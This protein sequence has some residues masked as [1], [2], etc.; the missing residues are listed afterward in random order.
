MVDE[1]K[2]NGQ[3]ELIEIPVE[4]LFHHRRNFIRNETEGS[5]DFRSNR[6][7]IQS[8]NVSTVKDQVNLPNRPGLFPE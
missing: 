7:D 8:S 2:P 6:F 5:W 3:A 1:V 4:C